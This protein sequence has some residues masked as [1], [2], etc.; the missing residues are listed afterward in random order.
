ML[1]IDSVVMDQMEAQHDGITEQIARFDEAEMPPCLHCGSADTAKVIAGVLSR[2][3]YI[4]SA[5]TKIK[6]LPNIL[7]EGAFFCNDCQKYFDNIPSIKG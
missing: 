5:T 4:A 1:K 6:L 3:I 2:T 7:D